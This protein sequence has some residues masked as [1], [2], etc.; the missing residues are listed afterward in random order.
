MK[1]KIERQVAIQEMKEDIEDMK[2]EVTLDIFMDLR[3][4]DS[5]NAIRFFLE[6]GYDVQISIHENRKKK[7]DLP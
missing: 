1:K 2:N 3:V 5:E 7:N 4:E 6:R